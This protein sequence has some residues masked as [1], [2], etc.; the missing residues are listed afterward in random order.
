MLDTCND[1]SLDSGGL[2]P[3]EAMSES[4]GLPT[5]QMLCDGLHK[6]LNNQGS[7]YQ[8]IQQVPKYGYGNDQF[9]N[10]VLCVCVVMTRGSD[11]SMPCLIR[12]LTH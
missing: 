9:A 7:T 5:T 2:K 11:F 6:V 4:G 1:D 10:P 8:G 12:L 3:V